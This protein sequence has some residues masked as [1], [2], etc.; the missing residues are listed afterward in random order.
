MAIKNTEL[1][2]RDETV[3]IRRRAIYHGLCALLPK[4][5]ALT[6]IKIWQAEFSDKPVYALQ[7]Y[8]TRLGAEFKFEASRNLI[9]RTLINALSLD[10]SE[11]PADPLSNEDIEKP[12]LIASGDAARVFTQLLS[13]FLHIADIHDQTVVLNIRNGLSEGI[14]ELDIPSSY[15]DHL[16]SM[17]LEPEEKI[18]LEGLTVEQMKAVLHLVYVQLCKYF[19]PVGTDRILSEAVTIT[20]TMPEAAVCP[21][22]SF[23]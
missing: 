20:E 12:Y 7:S 10:A 13:N 1:G 2:N 5:A 9:Q 22:R 21:P 6:A 3:A 14:K 15:F 23:L 18:L 8:I 11:L 19:G 17:L 16:I 4:K